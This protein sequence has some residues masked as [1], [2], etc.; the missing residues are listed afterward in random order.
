[1]SRID[2]A[3]FIMEGTDIGIDIGLNK[4]WNGKKRT[5]VNLAVGRMNTTR[6]PT[7]ACQP[8]C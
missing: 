8:P 4:L 5:N 3:I 2:D 6:T 7:A 1:M